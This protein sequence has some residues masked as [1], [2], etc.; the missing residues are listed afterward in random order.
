M[1]WS[2]CSKIFRPSRG[3]TPRT[4]SRGKTWSRSRDPC[5]E[6]TIPWAVERTTE[7][8]GQTQK[9]FDAEILTGICAVQ[10]AEPFARDARNQRKSTSA[11]RRGIAMSQ[12][13]ATH[14]RPGLAR[15]TPER[16]KS[17]IR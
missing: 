3:L 5:D 17:G 16:E 12:A 15:H 2:T 1:S 8:V 13:T 10:F 6:T 11:R 4:G 14:D 9:T 7:S